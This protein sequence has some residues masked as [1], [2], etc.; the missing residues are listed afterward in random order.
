VEFGVVSQAS[1]A[2]SR[3]SAA[4][5]VIVKNLDQLSGL[6]AETE[7]LGALAG[8]LGACAAGDG[9][10]GDVGDAAAVGAAKKGAGGRPTELKEQRLVGWGVFWGGGAVNGAG[11]AVHMVG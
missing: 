7:R 4:L 11:G 1:F 6:A 2:F 3:I 5:S 9:G 10:G 8:A